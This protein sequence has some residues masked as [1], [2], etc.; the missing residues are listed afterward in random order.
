M[1]D[2]KIS[3]FTDGSSVQATDEIATNRA[4]VNTKVFV[5]SA[6]ALDV[7]TGIGDVVQ[8]EDVASSAGLPAVDGSQLT[9]VNAE[10]ITVANESADTS[11]FILFGTAATGDL[12][13]KTNAALTFDSSTG[14]VGAA[15]FLGGFQTFSTATSSNINAVSGAV[16]S[17]TS[18][19]NYL[20]GG[21]SAVDYRVAIR[22]ATN[23]T[24]GANR[25]YASFIIGIQGATEAGS[26][27]HPILTNA[28]FLSPVF[29]NGAGATADLA[30]VY[31]QGAPSGVTPTGGTYAL[32]VD[33]GA[34]RF[35]G[36]VSGDGLTAT[37]R[38]YT[39]QQN[40]AQVALTSTA[41]SIAWNLNTAQTAVHT[42]TENTTL[43]NP[44]NMVAGG[45][46]IFKFI[47]SATPRTLAFGS[48]YKWPGG[49]APTVSTGSGDVD[50][51]T[52][53]SDGTNMYGTYQQDFS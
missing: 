5:G 16:T 46:Y 44:S 18:V 39:A 36:P 32:W 7:G 13:P 42:A 52:F 51:L 23:S 28:A 24:L 48:A 3:Q 20:F 12:E 50:I 9:G 4:G 29:V 11:C 26:G 41:A 53:Y 34:V 10:S 6:A 31:I 17:S 25:S 1:A 2:L 27:T 40:F 45:T 8:L 38:S 21:A 15:S 47:Q 37:A 22:G 14:Q 30:N 35:D 43:A 19:S 33:D 49:V